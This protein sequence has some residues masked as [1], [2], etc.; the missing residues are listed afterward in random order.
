MVPTVT[1]WMPVVGAVAFL[2][3]AGATQQWSLVGGGIAGLVT[4]ITAATNS[5]QVQSLRATG[6]PY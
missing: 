5:H 3:Y 1:K 4:A 6:R 2:V